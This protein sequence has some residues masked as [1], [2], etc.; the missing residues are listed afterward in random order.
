MAYTTQDVGNWY[1]KYLGRGLQNEGEAQ[2]WL[3]NPD[4]ERMIR[5]SGE[6]QAYAARQTTPGTNPSRPSV[7]N[8]WTGQTQDLTAWN[9]QRDGSAQPAPATAPATTPTSFA[10]E[11]AAIAAHPEN[12]YGNT[13]IEQQIRNIWNATTDHS[14]ATLARLAAEFGLRTTG[15][16]GDKIVMPDGRIIDAVMGAA[17]G[18]NAPGWIDTS[19]AGGVSRGSQGA[20]VR[21]QRSGGTSSNVTG[22]GTGFAYGT[23][24]QRDDLFNALLSRSKQS[25]NINPTDANIRTQADPYTAQVEREKRNYLADVAERQGP[26]ANIQGEARLASERAGQASGLFE[27]QL[28]GREMQARRDEIAQALASMQGMLS[29]EQQLALQRELAQL[30]AAIRNRQISSGNEQFLGSLGLQAENQAN[31]WDA[32]RSGLL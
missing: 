13:G 20:P 16:R 8:P 23:S 12:A 6:G 30:D 32:V 28:V 14:P 3:D 27:S 17:T 31:Y 4:A 11:R 15:T 25:L 18:Q 26:L 22:G 5:E 9:A 21:S 29:Q 24:G 2:G 7:T 19:V 1:Q 10:A